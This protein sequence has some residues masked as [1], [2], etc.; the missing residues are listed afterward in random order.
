MY[1]LLIPVESWG[2]L[3]ISL[4]VAL[5]LSS[6]VTGMVDLVECHIMLFM[7]CRSL[8]TWGPCLSPLGL[9]WQAF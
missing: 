7:T 2:L 3:L 4:L 6:G 8:S 1:S 5:I 9:V